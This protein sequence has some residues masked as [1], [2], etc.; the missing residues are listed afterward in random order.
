[1]TPDGDATILRMTHRGFSPR[2]ASGFAPGWHAYLDR[3]TAH[4][5]GGDLPDWMERY[6]QV[7]AAY[8]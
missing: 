5:A 3:L 2:N 7:Q 4:L 1:L 6:Q 8:R